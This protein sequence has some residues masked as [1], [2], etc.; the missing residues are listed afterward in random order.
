MQACLGEIPDLPFLRTLS[1][2]EIRTVRQMVVRGVN[3]PYTSSCG[4]LFDAVSALLGVCGR[5]TYEGHA[6]VELEMLAEDLPLVSTRSGYPFSIESRNGR[7]V[8]C[9]DRML[10]AILQ[11][12]KAGRS[13]CAISAGLH[14]T[15]AQMIVQ[16]CERMRAETGLAVTALSGGCF[17]NRRLLRLT[18]NQLGD[19]G[20]QVL[21]HRRVPCNDGGL[22]LGQAVVA[23]HLY[24]GDR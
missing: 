8:L 1:K 3:T 21:T 20:F 24:R 2:E 15:V 23:S 7:E 17:Q 13:A 12:L 18:A 6:A 16:M 19:R 11:A 4:R 22:S 5:A 14:I 10:G 9:M